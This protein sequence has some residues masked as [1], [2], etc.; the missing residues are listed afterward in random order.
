MNKTLLIIQREYLVRVKKRSFLIVTLLT[1]LLITALYAV[2]ALLFFASDEAKTIQI[3][4]ESNTFRGKLKN[5]ED[6][7]FTFIKG[8]LET[9][10]QKLRNSDATAL[11]LIPKDI[12][13]KPGGLQIFA[14]KTVSMGL[15]RRIENVVQS[16]VRNQRLANAGI[17]VKVVE[18]NRVN[19]DAQT[20]SLNEE[21]EK[22]S[23]SGV[24]TGIGYAIALIL[25]MS[26]FLSGSQVMNGVIEEKSNRIIEIVISSVK[27]MQLLLGKIIGV[28]LVGLT[29]F[30][31][32]I[33]LTALISSAVTGLLKNKLEEKVRK[34]VS[35]SA[36]PEQA[37]Q[38]QAQLQA[39]NPMAKVN[40]ALANLPLGKL[41]LCF[42]FYYITGF[43]LYS[44]LFAAVGSAVENPS[45]AQQLLFPVTIPLIL[46]II[47]MTY[48]INEPD[49]KVAFWA[50][51]IPFTAPVDMMARLPFGVETWELLLSMSLMIVGFLSTTWLAARIY[52]VGI[53]MY[54][55]K[56]TLRELSKW[57][58]YKA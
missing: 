17:D 44:S 7:I 18:D 5:D 25:Y 16:E 40:E 3:L 20:Y 56:A 12:V 30:M 31:L 19:V 11:V 28:G 8:S 26:V 57:V 35:V 29:Q 39:Q 33:L 36:S 2:P 24:A 43:L 49:S 23:N 53:L 10:K 1:P 9:A 37:K 32:W 47:L 51:I 52:R 34:E 58:F 38:V 4:D 27:P 54:G 55:K 41:L 14:E 22:S 45:E 50:S 46:S 42:I 15:Q 21:G 48:V 6:Y 13:E